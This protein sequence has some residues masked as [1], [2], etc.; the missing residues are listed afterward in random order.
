VYGKDIATKFYSDK[1]CLKTINAVDIISKFGYLTPMIHLRSIY[2]GSHGSTE[3]NASFQIHIVK[4]I[5]EE[6][7]SN[8]PNFDNEYEEDDDDEFQNEN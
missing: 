3:Y 6:K 8:I 4:A 7:P 2:Y 5:F 1:K